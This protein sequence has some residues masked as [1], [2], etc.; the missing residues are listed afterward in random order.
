M[1]NAKR[2]RVVHVVLTVLFLLTAVLNLNHIRAGFLT[3]H[4]ADLVVPAWMYVVARAPYDA[5]KRKTL[6]QWSL[7]RSPEFAA[8]SLFI[9]SALSEVSQYYWPTGLFRGRFDPL[10]ILAYAVGLVAVYV[11]DKRS[12]TPP[13]VPPTR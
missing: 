5:N 3:N 10:D 13:A 6:L 2:W 7:G 4:L 12:G 9:A 1:T 8:G 11:A